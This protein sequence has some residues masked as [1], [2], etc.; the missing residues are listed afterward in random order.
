MS[1]SEIPD[2]I[3][4]VRVTEWLPNGMPVCATEGATRRELEDHIPGAGARLAQLY[5]KASHK[6]RNMPDTQT[7]HQQE[8]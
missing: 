5:A 6:L 4:E 8:R 3:V 1:E 7:P 2:A